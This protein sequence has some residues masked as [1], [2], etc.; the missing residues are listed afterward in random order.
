MKLL[1][2]LFCAF[3]AVINAFPYGPSYHYPGAYYGHPAHYDYYGYGAGYYGPRGYP[4]YLDGRG[5][6]SGKSVWDR[7]LENII[8]VHNHPHPRSHIALP[9]QGG[10]EA[11]VYEEGSGFKQG[12]V[13]A[14]RWPAS[15]G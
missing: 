4:T 15:L 7:F 8:T 11:S 5:F 2:A 9:R 1:L 14:N 10:Q 3:L 13:D 6:K 12:G